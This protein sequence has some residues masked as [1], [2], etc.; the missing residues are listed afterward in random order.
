ME[1]RS[2]MRKWIMASLAITALFAA[3]AR[4][5]TG[6]FPPLPPTK[7]PTAN[8]HPNP[9]FSGIFAHFRGG[10]VLP[11]FQAAPWYLYWPYDA[12]FL[13]PA[14]MGGAFYPPPMM[15]NYPVQPYFPASQPQWRPA[16]G[17]P[18]GYGN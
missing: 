13:M 9:F 7:G 1:S 4:A 8:D 18:L 12:H 3:D 10:N 16:M 5:D 14:P 17:A 6:L 11:V 15:G 2:I